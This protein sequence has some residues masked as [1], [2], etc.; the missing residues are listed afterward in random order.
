MNSVK[1]A[2]I[3]FLLLCVCLSVS[4]QVFNSVCPSHDVS[5]ISLT[6]PISLSQPICIPQLFSLP[7]HFAFLPY[8]LSL[9]LPPLL[10]SP[11]SPPLTIPS[12]LPFPGEHPFSPLKG[13]GLVMWYVF[14]SPISI[15]SARQHA[16]RAICYRPSV[17][18]SVCLSVCPSVRHTGGSVE[19]G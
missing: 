13:L 6:Q 1:L 11:L 10:P 15:F 3:L 16:E 8:P 5:A 17:R 7:N 4:T 9:P 2:D 18:L 12:S 14:C 19:N